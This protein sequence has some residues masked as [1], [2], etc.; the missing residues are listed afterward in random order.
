MLIRIVII[1]SFALVT[2]CGKLGKTDVSQAAASQRAAG[3]AAIL[4]TGVAVIDTSDL[5][6]IDGG[7]PELQEAEHAETVLELNAPEAKNPVSD[8]PE[9]KTAANRQSST[10]PEP[11]EGADDLRAKKVEATKPHSE[12]LPPDFD[13]IPDSESPNVPSRN[14]HRRLW[15]LLSRYRGQKAP[16]TADLPADEP[17][18]ANPPVSTKK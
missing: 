15:A 6:P 11:S 16:A 13:A 10:V 18:A 17:I 9:P 3:K 2:G 8:A 14:D 1:S 4:R 12:M 5:P 7:N